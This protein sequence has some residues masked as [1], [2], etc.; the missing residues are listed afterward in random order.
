[1]PNL[2]RLQK[3]PCTLAKI[4]DSLQTT[5]PITY[6]IDFEYK[7]IDVSLGSLDN[8]SASVKEITWLWTGSTPLLEQMMT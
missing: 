6:F 8:E 7:Y 4:T 2:R 1:M 3:R 5:F